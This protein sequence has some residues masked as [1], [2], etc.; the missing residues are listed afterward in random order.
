M[1]FDRLTQKAQEA[2]AGTQNIALENGNQQIETLHLVKSLLNESDGVVRPLLEKLN[3]NIT[4]LDSNVDS[5]I[6]KMKYPGFADDIMLRW[7][8]GRLYTSMENCF[9]I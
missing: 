5:A 2:V 7:E 4:V 3:I 6:A 8:E 9:K 1:K